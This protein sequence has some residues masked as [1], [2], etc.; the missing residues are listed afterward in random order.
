MKVIGL[1][2]GIGCG[3]STVAGMLRAHGVAGVD[4]EQVA[5]DVVAMGSAGLAAVVQAFGREVLAPDGTLDRKK[6]GAVVFDDE[7]KRRELNAILHP[8]I[9]AESPTRMMAL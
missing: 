3:K 4:A 6:L 9:G 2:G 5:R 1:T 7:T 8:R